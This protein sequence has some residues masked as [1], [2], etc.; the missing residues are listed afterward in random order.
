MT[1]A[2]TQILD[3]TSAATDKIAELI[4]TRGKPGL[5][6]RVGI[7]GTLPGGGYQTEF[8]FQD[9][10]NATP[11]DIVQPAGEFDFLFDPDVA[12]KVQG[13]RVDYDDQRYAAGFNIEYPPAPFG[14]PAERI[15]SD[16][17]DPLAVR[18]QQVINEYINPGVAGHGGWV[19]L[20][21]VKSTSV[22]VEMGGGCQ[23]CGLSAVTL[24]QGIERAIM[25]AV[26][27]VTEVIDITE[28]GEG[29]NPY[30]SQDAAQAVNGASPLA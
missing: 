2:S 25:E 1:E 9:R 6:V 3:V 24:R 30:Y 12:K 13:C 19:L 4:R 20:T 15:R 27:E 17:S 21:D 8:K 26:P 22:Y 23:G 14:P 29:E 5:A 18:V 16:W 11:E 28:H 7:R 10:R